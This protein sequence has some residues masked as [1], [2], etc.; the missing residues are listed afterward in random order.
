VEQGV[1]AMVEQ[2]EKAITGEHCCM[3]ASTPGAVHSIEAVAQHMVEM[4]GWSDGNDTEVQRTKE[5]V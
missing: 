4:T 3:G 2:V 5:E 1:K